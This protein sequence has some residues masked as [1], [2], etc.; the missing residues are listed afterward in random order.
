M[1]TNDLLDK[2]YAD[3]VDMTVPIVKLTPTW[4]DMLEVFN[5]VMES[6]VDDPIEQMERIRF[7]SED[8]EDAMLAS[9]ARLLG[10]DLS[11]DVLSMNGD[12]LIKLVT[13]LPLYADQN[14]TDLFVK[15]IDL[16]F[17]AQT[18]VQNLYT[19]DYVNFLD[20]PKGPL[21]I[22]KGAW[23]KTTHIDLSIQ[24]FHPEAIV[25]NEGVKLID[26]VRELFFQLAPVALV[27]Y[28]TSFIEEMDDLVLGIDTYM[29]YAEATVVID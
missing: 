5:R 26:R 12:N 16:I 14:G 21:I 9:T 28:R 6:N 27:V 24:L 29:P 13:Q 23:F 4:D 10:F 18:L 2:P 3:L 25:L 1:A 11:A 17:N 15:F 20:A 7:I 19:Q 22:D 8:S